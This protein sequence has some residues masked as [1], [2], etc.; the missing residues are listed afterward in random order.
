VP[1]VPSQAGVWRKRSSPSRS[2][3]RA[4]HRA[5]ARPRRR[6]LDSVR[7]EVGFATR[8]RGTGSD[9]KE[10]PGSLVSK[11]R[12]G[13][14]EHAGDEQGGQCES[15]CGFAAKQG[16]RR[17][18]RPGGRPRPQ[19]QRRRGG[20]GRGARVRREA[21]PDQGPRRRPQARSNTRA[22]CREMEFGLQARR[23]F[24]FFFCGPPEN[25]YSQKRR[26]RTQ[27][28]PKKQSRG[29]RRPGEK[30]SG[31]GGIL[32]GMRPSGRPPFRCA[33]AGDLGL[34]AGV[35]RSSFVYQN[36]ATRVVV[37]N[38]TTGRRRP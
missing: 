4:G 34:L 24:F 7:R 11:G 35:C 36:T 10:W 12:A 28:R 21:A 17:R 5:H 20:Q 30:G 26:S 16:P 32:R 19:A 27:A 6:W 18:G 2:G 33:A 13:E 14:S 8:S 22:W 25:A 23:A 38:S 3:A 9:T 31:R 29:R 15:V 1:P 37:D